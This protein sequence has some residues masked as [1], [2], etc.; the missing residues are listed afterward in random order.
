MNA[1]SVIL[2]FQ[3][4]NGKKRIEQFQLLIAEKFGGR[5]TLQLPPHIT[6]IKWQSLAPL[7]ENHKSS[8]VVR[9][10]L[11]DVTLEPPEISPNGNSIWHR[12]KNPDKLKSLSAELINT[13]LRSGIGNDNI[14]QTTDYHLTLAYK[15]YSEKKV[16]AIFAFLKQSY[17][18]SPTS[19]IATETA[20]C[21]IDD[22]GT[23]SL[24]A[25]PITIAPKRQ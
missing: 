15:D 17:P 2:L 21:G 9:N 20:I 11:H 19:L 3:D 18:T 7:S 10:M 8:L 25:E 13:L 22:R 14:L 23:W 6:L 24:I 16:E 12:V 5:S 1:H 4:N